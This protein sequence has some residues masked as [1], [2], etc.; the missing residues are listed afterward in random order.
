MKMKKFLENDGATR[1]RRCSEVE[2]VGA[3]F[4]QSALFCRKRKCSI[5]F[6]VLKKNYFP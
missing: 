5:G 4:A 2:R 6:S 3:P 1:E